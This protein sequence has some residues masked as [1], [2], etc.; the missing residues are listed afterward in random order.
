MKRAS[1]SW[2]SAIA[3]TKIFLPAGEFNNSSSFKPY[4]L[5]IFDVISAFISLSDFPFATLDKSK[6]FDVV[7]ILSFP[8]TPSLPLPKISLTNS[9]AVL[10]LLKSKS[11]KVSGFEAI[12]SLIA[13]PKA[14]WSFTSMP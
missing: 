12:M 11:A 7:Y 2:S 1:L 3:L 10:S 6:I 8:A 13:S 4:W 9:S 5:A 14:S